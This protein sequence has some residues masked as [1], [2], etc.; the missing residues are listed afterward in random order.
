MKELD[1]EKI[2]GMNQGEIIENFKMYERTIMQKDSEIEK[3]KKENQDFIREFHQKDKEIYDLKKK[4]K[5]LNIERLGEIN[6][7]IIFQKVSSSQLTHKN[8]SFLSNSICNILE[9]QKSE[10]VKSLNFEILN[11][12]DDLPF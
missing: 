1:I 10:I 7:S 9:I 6:A 8:K 12:K 4:I 2:N 3:L 5:S 11:G